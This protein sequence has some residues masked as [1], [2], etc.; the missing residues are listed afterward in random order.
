MSDGIGFGAMLFGPEHAL[1]LAATTIESSARTSTDMAVGICLGIRAAIVEYQRLFT[2]TSD[3]MDTVPT[4]TA[5]GENV[6]ENKPQE[7]SKTA[8]D[9][10]A[11]L[12]DA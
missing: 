12:S 10:V 7:K 11:A 5:K 9:R 3:K 6:P 1:Q 2:P 8:R 4:Q